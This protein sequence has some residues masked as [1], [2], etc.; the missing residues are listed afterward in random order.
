MTDKAASVKLPHRNQ[1]VKVSITLL[2]Y[3]EGPIAPE[4]PCDQFG[5]AAETAS[6]GECNGLRTRLGVEAACHQQGEYAFFAE[7]FRVRDLDN[8]TLEFQ[9]IG[10]Y[11]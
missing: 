7:H 3:D 9:I 5:R 8:L 10:Q 2:E 4:D 6:V 1:G 11:V